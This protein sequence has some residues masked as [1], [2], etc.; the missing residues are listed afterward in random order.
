LDKNVNK[1]TTKNVLNWLIEHQD[2]ITDSRFDAKTNT[3]EFKI[4]PTKQ[5]RLNKTTSIGLWYA[6]CHPFFT[7]KL[8]WLERKN[9]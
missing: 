7:L 9:E 8:W 3:F 5:I 4:R 2:L 6:I 1:Y